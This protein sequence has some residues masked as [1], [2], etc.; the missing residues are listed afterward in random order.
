MNYTQ[1]ELE[2]NKILSQ[3][4][5]PLIIDGVPLYTRGLGKARTIRN[6]I[7]RLDEKGVQ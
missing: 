6:I 4:T 2:V 1:T 7:R 3:N 5:S